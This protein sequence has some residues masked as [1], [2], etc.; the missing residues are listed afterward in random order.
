MTQNSVRERLKYYLM[1][2]GVK[3][4]FICNEIDM[5]KEIMSR[6]VHGK[7]EIYLSHLDLLDRFLKENKF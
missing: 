3:Q 2:T 5:P 1:T 4:V 6:F 7:I